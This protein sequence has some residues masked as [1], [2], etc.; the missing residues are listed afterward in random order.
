MGGLEIAEVYMALLLANLRA[1][2]W[3][4]SVQIILVGFGCLYQVRHSHSQ[5]ATRQPLP[6]TARAATYSES[7]A[8]VRSDQR[9]A[10]A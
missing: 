6:S 9:V 8:N 4:S 5:Y 10:S 3:L 2:A 1:F 7:R